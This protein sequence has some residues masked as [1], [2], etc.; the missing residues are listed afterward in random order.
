MFVRVHDDDVWTAPLLKCLYGSTFYSRA[1]KQT[2]QTVPLAIP[3]G[4]PVQTSITLARSKHPLENRARMF[5]RVHFDAMFVRVHFRGARD[6]SGRR[7]RPVQTSGIRAQKK[8]TFAMF[9]R[10]HFARMFV[11]VSFFAPT[12]PTRPK[13]PGCENP[14]SEAHG[15]PSARP[16]APP[17]VCTGP[18]WG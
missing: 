8:L 15:E 7:N 11:R 9:A 10:V 5:V 3:R 6:P 17:D 12:R 13:H 1:V 18:V 16:I 2:S 4:G 14:F